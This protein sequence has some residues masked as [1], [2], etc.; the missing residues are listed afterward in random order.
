MLD[1]AIVIACWIKPDLIVKQL[2]SIVNLTGIDNYNVIIYQD[3]VTGSSE[4]DTTDHKNLSNKLLNIIQDYKHHIPNVEHIVADRNL[5]PYHIVRESMSYA[6]SKHKYVIYAEDDVIFAKNALNW[7]NYFYDNDF[8]SLSKYYF[9][10]GESLF[11]DTRNININL[12]TIDRNNLID[13]INE[14]KLYKYFHIV[15]DFLPSSNFATTREVWSSPVG[16][17]RGTVVGDEL[18]NFFIKRYH[19]MVRSIFPLIPFSKDIGML[20]DKGWSVH[21]VGKKNIKEVKNV[22][23]LADSFETSESYNELPEGINIDKINL[24]VL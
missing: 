10:V 15:E 16:E 17:V 13:Y 22:S 7:F 1:R 19:P 20:H 3:T 23:I 18:L 24:R 6:F 5:G 8:I 14:Y 11:C 9:C 4:W 21:H 2:E 12:D